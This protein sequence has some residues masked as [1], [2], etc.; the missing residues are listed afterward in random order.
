MY[1]TG[2]YVSLK[3]VLEKV[4]RD[5]DGII[6]EIQWADAIEWSAEA[7]NLLGLYHSYV[8]KISKKITINN[9]RG[10]LPCDIAFIKM[11][12]DFNSGI[13]L[14]RSF[15]QFHLSNHYR[16]EEEQVSDCI[17]CHGIPTYTVNNNYIF[18]S[19]KEGEI[20]M[21]YKGLLTDEFDIP[22]IPDDTKFIRAVASYI[23]ERCCFK[24]VLQNKM[25]ESIYKGIVERDRD[26]AFGSAKS[27]LE[28]P[29]LDRMESF[30]NKW[31][32]LIPSINHHNTAFKLSSQPQQ[33]KNHNSY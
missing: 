22:M 29:D 9:Y 30:K 33:Q 24:L 7:I 4:L 21:S 28:I 11:V 16:C 5:Y 19:F 20:E 18:T 32:R 8:D 31:I 17:D 6:T 23:A 10:E 2:K 1:N 3:T 13:T 25:S 26:W 14:I 12:R 15:D 27:S